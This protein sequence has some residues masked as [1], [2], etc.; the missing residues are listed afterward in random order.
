LIPNEVILIQLLPCVATA[1]GALSTSDPLLLFK[2]KERYAADRNFWGSRG[3]E[4]L[5]RDLVKMS[6]WLRI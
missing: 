4:T 1:S 3:R 5:V 6:G 2:E